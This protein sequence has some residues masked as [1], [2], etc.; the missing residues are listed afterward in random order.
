MKILLCDSLIQLHCELVSEYSRGEWSAFIQVK[1]LR[2]LLSLLL[3]VLSLHVSF[4]IAILYWSLAVERPHFGL[5]VEQ[6]PF[7]SFASPFRRFFC[8]M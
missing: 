6:A 2:L 3:D 5:L 8:E 1:L 7:S 4:L